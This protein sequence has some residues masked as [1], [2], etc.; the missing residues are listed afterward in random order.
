MLLRSQPLLLAA[1]HLY[2]A[3]IEATLTLCLVRWP[4]E[5]EFSLHPGVELVRNE[6]LLSPPSALTIP[7]A[8]VAF[9]LGSLTSA[10]TVPITLYTTKAALFVTLT[11]QAAGRFSDNAF[12]LLP[13][14]TSIIDF[15]PW[16]SGGLT[17]EGLS[18]LHSTL[19]VEHLQQ[20]LVHNASS[21]AGRV[22]TNVK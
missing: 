5:G 6:L 14:A 15:I 4:T 2:A 13:S 20:Y 12:L 7:E 17:E 19:R 8:N 9:K 18:L 21:K 16:D 11:T 3:Q 10:G 22:G 1:K